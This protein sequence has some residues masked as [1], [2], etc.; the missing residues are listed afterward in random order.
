MKA[1]LVKRGRILRLLEY[2]WIKKNVFFVLNKWILFISDS[3]NAK[4]N[5]TEKLRHEFDDTL[6]QLVDKSYQ[7]DKRSYWKPE[8][9]ECC[10]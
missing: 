2:G 4:R 5:G 6:G 7:S 10:S 9:A 8:K 1:L 3:I